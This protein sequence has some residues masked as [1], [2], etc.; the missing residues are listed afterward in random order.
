MVD[1][2]DVVPED[3]AGGVGR[4]FG[5]VPSEVGICLPSGPIDVS[6][7]GLVRA[8][9]GKR[10]LAEIICRLEVTKICL[11]VL[12]RPS[13]FPFVVVLDSLGGILVPRFSVRSRDERS[14]GNV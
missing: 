4:A 8:C 13:V 2:T 5:P 6:F 12:I 1:G 14:I 9:D 10:I 3:G 11:V 7:D